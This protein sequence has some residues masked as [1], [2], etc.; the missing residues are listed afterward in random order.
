MNDIHVIRSA[1]KSLALTVLKD[2]EIQVRA[3]Y[4]I[5]DREIREF[6]EKHSDWIRKQRQ[7]LSRAEN[8]VRLT[9]EE[10]IKLAEAA[11]LD[12]PQRV[13]FFSSRM[14]IAYGRITIRNQKSKWGSCSSEGNLNFNCL[15]MLAPENVR[16][17]VVVHE[18]C[19]RRQMNHSPAFWAEVESVLP[20][21]RERRRWLREHGTELMARNPVS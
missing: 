18:L 5:S 4:Y 3:P 19:H 21:Y 13:A 14:G 6:T 10:L 1:R 20:D 16:D 7:T 17:Y 8:Q 9:E 15:L 2:G 11:K 12:L